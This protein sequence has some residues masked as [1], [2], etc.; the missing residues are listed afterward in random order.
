MK[1]LYRSVRWL[2]AVPLAVAIG[3]L[4]WLAVAATLD[5]FG[6]EPPAW[7]FYLA[8]SYGY[9]AAGFVGAGVATRCVPSRRVLV[10]LV[11]VGAALGVALVLAT[12]GIHDPAADFVFGLS[13]F[14]GAVGNAL[15]KRGFSVAGHAGA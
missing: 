15:R 12:A 6:V 10:S 2:A 5:A 8:M 3:G 9:L 13:L 1:R 4:V 7:E 11:M 14:A